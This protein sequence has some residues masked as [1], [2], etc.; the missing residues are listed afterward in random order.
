MASSRKLGLQEVLVGNDLYLF[1]ADFKFLQS[2]K[3]NSSYDPMEIYDSFSSGKCDL[4]SVIDILSCSMVSINKEP[5]NNPE[6]T[7]ENLISMFGLQECWFL[8]YKLLSDSMIGDIKKS[9]LLLD[10]KIQKLKKLNF[11]P[12]TSLRKQP[13]LWVYQ[14][15]I[16]GTCLWVSFKLISPFFT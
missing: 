14:A 10:E 5:I 16:F 15:W 3:E 9:E 4:D 13:F 7:A 1:K 8:C 12:S 2:L 11:S 6:K